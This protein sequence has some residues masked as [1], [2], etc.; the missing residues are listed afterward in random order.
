MTQLK[1]VNESDFFGR[2]RPDYSEFVKV[3]KDIEYEK[4]YEVKKVI[5]KKNRKYDNI[6]MT[7]YLIRWLKYDFEFD[8]WKSFF[9]LTD[10]MDLIEEYEKNIVNEQFETR[11]KKKD[12]EKKNVKK[13]FKKISKKLSK[14]N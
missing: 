11:S 1:S 14:N 13:I 3:E 5:S 6:E 8:E 12:R 10:C 9:A 7:Q 2:K 4:S